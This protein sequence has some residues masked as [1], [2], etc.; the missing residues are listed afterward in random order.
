MSLL[1]WLKNAT[2]GNTTEPLEFG[3][4]EE[5]FR[6]L[7]MKDALDAH[8]AWTQRLEK[9]LSGENKDDIEVATV[10][11]DHKCTL[12]H[13]IHNEAKQSFGAITEYDELKRVHADF[14]LKVGEVLNNVTNGNETEAKSGMR[15]IRGKSG[16]VQLSLIRLYSVAKA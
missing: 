16:E 12:G 6:G 11:V 5:N 15:E 7:N 8:T 10:A 4:G 3:A 13:W 1:N 9:K 14:H 2:S